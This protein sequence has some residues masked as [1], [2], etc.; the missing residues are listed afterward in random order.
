MTPGHLILNRILLVSFLPLPLIFSTMLIG[1]YITAS[2]QGFRVLDG[3]Y[4]QTE[5]QF[6]V[7]EIF[8]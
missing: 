8:F 4:V 3:P 6:P 1:V 7:P 2:H 5:F